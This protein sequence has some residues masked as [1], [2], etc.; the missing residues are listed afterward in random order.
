MAKYLWIASYTP[1][2]TKGL[3]KDGGS[4]RR[5]AIEQLA[6]SVG[7]HVDALYYAFGEQDAY[8]I[9]DLP[10]AASAAAISLTVAASGAARVR[11]VP[12][13]TVEEIDQACKKAV[14]YRAPGK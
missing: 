12:L 1:E 4:G 6:K 3:L 11:T 8:I 10:D 2:G 7:G 9:V 13:I 14:T 5:N